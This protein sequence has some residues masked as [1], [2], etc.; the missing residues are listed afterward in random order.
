MIAGLRY[1]YQRLPAPFVS[2]RTNLAPRLGLAWQPRG[3]GGWV[4]RFGAGL[5]Y[6]RYPFAF[7]N[8]ALQKDGVRGFEQYAVGAG[9]AR[10]FALSRGGTLSAPLDGLAHSVYRPDPSFDRTPTY[11]RKF[12]AGLERSLNADT[13]LTI[14]YMN[15]AGFHLPRLRNAA[16]TLPPQFSLEQS[17][18]SRY[19]GVSVTLH[20]RLSK[21]L[22][23]LLAY[24]A[25]DARDDASD[26]DEQPLDPANTR[27]DW[28]RSRQYQ[29]HRVVA[30]GIFEL[31]LERL[32]A[33]DWLQNIGDRLDFAPVVSLGTP[34]PVNALATTDLYRTGAYPITARPAGLDRNP[35]Y[36]RGIFNVD[37]RLTKGFVWWKE[38]GIFLFGLG[39][40]NL[41]NHTNGLRLSPYYGL[42]TYR[43]LIE[44][45]NARQ[46]QFSFQWEF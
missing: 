35:F 42:D 7:L 46:A 36:S 44:T 18:G 29:A 24:T 10:A 40:Y 33:P 25:G 8:D 34:R 43:G 17:A 27:A 19:R 12:T 31:P 30:S 38:H 15:I 26:F 41:T 32:D 4:F 9:A 28:S 22:T 13:T 5:F 23:Y 16:L 21:E 6:D 45:L 2:P 20:R 39:F 14:E 1:E 37:L 11:A 3:H